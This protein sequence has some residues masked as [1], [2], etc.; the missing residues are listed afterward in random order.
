MLYKPSYR[1]GTQ[2]QRHKYPRVRSKRNL[3]SP[4]PPRSAAIIS[5]VRRPRLPHATSQGN[6]A[7]EVR[8]PLA[9]GC[10]PGPDIATVWSCPTPPDTPPR[11]YGQTTH[12]FNTIALS[13]LQRPTCPQ[14]NSIERHRQECT[15]GSA[16]TQIHQGCQRVV[17]S[18][19]R[20]SPTLWGNHCGSDGCDC[21]PHNLAEPLCPRRLRHH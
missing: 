6:C 2:P 12:T 13:A 1:K 3:T 21:H 14:I 9:S 18:S 16:Y 11:G 5:V 19:S 4:H 8:T 10:P 15:H 20:P 7:Q 17:P